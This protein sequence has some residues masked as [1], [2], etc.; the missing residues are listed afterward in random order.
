MALDDE[1][2]FT[3][4]FGGSGSADGVRCTEV[5]TGADGAANF[6]GGVVR[7]LFEGRSVELPS[8]AAL[9]TGLLP[10]FD[11]DVV[12]LHFWY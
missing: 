5:G 4:D 1:G 3:E 12:L 11:V 10:G 2:K 8:R 9:S 7:R 6:R